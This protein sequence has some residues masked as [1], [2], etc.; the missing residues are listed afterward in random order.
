[1]PL[2]TP[3]KSTV[4]V[5]NETK[6]FNFDDY[7][8]SARSDLDECSTCSDNSAFTPIQTPI[9]ETNSDI[10]TN[11]I[12]LQMKTTVEAPNSLV[13]QDNDEVMSLESACALIQP[14]I[15]MSHFSVD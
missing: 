8:K 2:I 1:M 9:H 5:K 11:S 10:W 15:L 7:I 3:S 12:D 13:I 6:L 14:P 4:S